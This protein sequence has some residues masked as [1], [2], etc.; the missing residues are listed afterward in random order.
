M[1][2][3]EN[4][5]S[6]PCLENARFLADFSPAERTIGRYCDK[7]NHVRFKR[8]LDRDDKEGNSMDWRRKWKE[9]SKRERWSTGG[10][11]RYFW[12]SILVECREKDRQRKTDRESEKKMQRYHGRSLE[13]YQISDQ[14]KWNIFSKASRDFLILNINDTPVL[15]LLYQQSTLF[16]SWNAIILV[17][18]EDLPRPCIHIKYKTVGLEIDQRD[19]DEWYEGKGRGTT[20]L[21]R[22]S[23]VLSESSGDRPVQI[24]FSL[25]TL[26]LRNAPS[27]RI[28]VKKWTKFRQY[29]I[30]LIFKII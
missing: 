28:L 5:I 19:W 4:R 27:S 15:S 18:A 24:V 3:R 13:S 2:F 26:F 8:K 16:Y 17:V 1:I 29:L 11:E 14:A 30:S 21:E 23:P 7:S 10:K 20:R 25:A 12:G 6:E 22:S 9:F